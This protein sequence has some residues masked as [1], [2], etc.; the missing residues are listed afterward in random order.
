M[1]LKTYTRILT[2][3][4]ETT[5]A[6]LK[7][8]HGTEPHLAFAFDPWRLVG[9]GDV[10]VVAGTEEA[11]EPIRGSLGPWIVEDIVAARS[12]ILE[13]GASIVREIED[14]GTG[15]MMYVRHADGHVVEYVQWLPELAERLVFAPLRAGTLSSRI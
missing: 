12:K 13:N 4:L 1:V 8:I 5:V 14:V 9:I 10:L 11:L 7:A 6:A 2:T 15:R 3:D